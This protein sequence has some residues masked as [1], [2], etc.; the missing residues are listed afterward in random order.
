MRMPTF[1][2]VAV[3]CW[4]AANLVAVVL[5]AFPK[6]SLAVDVLFGGAAG[7]AD[8]NTATNWNPNRVP[9]GTDNATFF[10]GHTATITSDTPT[11]TDLRFGD[12][13]LFGGEVDQS[14][15]TL[16]ATGQLRMNMSGTATSTYTISGGS[17]SFTRI[18]V[19]ES[20]GS[21]T[22][23]LNVQGGTLTI[24]TSNAGGGLGALFINGGTG[25]GTGIVN[26]SAGILSVGAD[27]L[28]DKS[29]E[30]GDGG[31][32][33]A[34][35]NVSGAGVVDVTGQGDVN[36]GNLSPGAINQSGG[37]MNLFTSGAAWL[38][39]GRNA[40]GSYS[41]SGWKTSLLGLA[42]SCRGR[43]SA[44]GRGRRPIYSNPST[45]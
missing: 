40:N 9:T 1:I 2:R 26:V 14:T 35:F 10:N 31:T 33:T 44:G 21:A 12:G 22:S 20:A 36:V 4:L 6:K 17:A 13:T 19:N 45:T 16:N 29:I 30:V 32:N 18:N 27:T 41:L 3:R 42:W 8:W 28:D 37:T 11:F 39:V 43:R 5:A 38:Y 23:T 34:Q 24:P 25:S 15:G 7:P